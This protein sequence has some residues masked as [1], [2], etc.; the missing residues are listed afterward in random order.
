MMGAKLNTQM[1]MQLEEARGF[2][3]FMLRNKRVSWAQGKVTMHPQ[4]RGGDSQCWGWR[5]GVTHLPCQASRVQG[6]SLWG[7]SVSARYRELG[8]RHRGL[9]PGLSIWRYLGRK[10]VVERACRSTLEQSHL[11]AS[12]KPTPEEKDNRKIEMFIQQF[13]EQYAAGLI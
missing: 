4:E 10:G 12:S 13:Q 3:S 11:K 2:L 7:S 6:H 8:V 1:W 9:K 5:G